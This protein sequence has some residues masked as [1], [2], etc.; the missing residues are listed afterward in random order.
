MHQMGVKYGDWKFEGPCEDHELPVWDHERRHWTYGHAVAPTPRQA[1]KHLDYFLQGWMIAG[2][3]EPTMDPEWTYSTIAG[4]QEP[5]SDPEWTFDSTDSS[6]T[7][8]EESQNETAR[9]RP[10]NG[11]PHS[12]SWQKIK[13]E[14]G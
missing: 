10:G 1:R 12:E 5:T 7:S 6:G 14:E 11:A 13:C 3:Q 8:S 4:T 9:T 2:M